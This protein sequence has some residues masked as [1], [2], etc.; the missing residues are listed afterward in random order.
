M[1]KLKQR[2]DGRYRRTVNGRTFY[3]K[4]EREVNRKIL[5]YKE[6]AERGRTFGEVAAEWQDIA[7]NA[8]ETQTIKSYK[9]PYKRAVE[10]FGQLPIKTIEPKDIS[11]FLLRMAKQGYAQK[12]VANHLIVVNQI[13]AHALTYGEIQVNPCT[14]VKIPKGLPKTKRYAASEQDEYIVATTDYPWIFPKIALYT[15]MRKGEILALQWRDIDFERNVISVTKS[16]AHENNNPYVKSPKTEAGVRMVPLLLPL[17]EI[18][19]AHKGK[20]PPDNYLISDDGKHPL[21]N[22]RFETQYRHFREATG[23]TCTAHQLRHSF[24][25]IAVEEGIDIKPLQMIMGHSSSLIT[26]DTYA[27]LRQKGFDTAASK[28]NARYENKNSG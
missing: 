6:A 15:G 1:A 10:Q 21:T 25:T 8:L 13:L 19:I 14:A 17:R 18:L 3:G 4:T 22:K 2:S 26:L 12:T 27:D 20:Q 24:A 28:L 7:W 16:I 5:E 11:L 9:T 23:V